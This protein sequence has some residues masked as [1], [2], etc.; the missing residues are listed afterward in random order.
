MGIIPFALVVFALAVVC[1]LDAD[2][3]FVSDKMAAKVDAQMKRLDR[4]VARYMNIE[5]KLAEKLAADKEANKFAQSILNR[6]IHNKIDG[7]RV[8]ELLPVECVGLV[9]AYLFV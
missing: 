5:R 9:Y 3:L 2:D 1:A 8:E 7:K 6:H 4:L